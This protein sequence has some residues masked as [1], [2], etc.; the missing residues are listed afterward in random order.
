MVRHTLFREGPRLAT[1]EGAGEGTFYHTFA[2]MDSPKPHA[3]IQNN[4]Y[5]T[6]YLEYGVRKWK[7]AGRSGGQYLDDAFEAVSKQSDKGFVRR[8][9]KEWHKKMKEA[10]KTGQV[11]KGMPGAN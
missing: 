5:Y 11:P 6:K 1:D 3:W 4:V 2:N 8:N 7:S 10:L 9:I